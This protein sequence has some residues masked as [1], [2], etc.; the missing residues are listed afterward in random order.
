MRFAFTS[1]DFT[2]RFATLK[3]LLVD[4][5]ISFSRPHLAFLQYYSH[6]VLCPAGP[7][8]TAVTIPRLYIRGRRDAFRVPAFFVEAEKCARFCKKPVKTIPM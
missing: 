3:N 7:T 2:N 4:P 5:E 6:F 1:L 8:A